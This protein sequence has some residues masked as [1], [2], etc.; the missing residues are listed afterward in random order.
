M[1][2]TLH[3]HKHIEE[4]GKPIIPNLVFKETVEKMKAGDKEVYEE[5]T[6]QYSLTPFQKEF[7]ERWK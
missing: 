2:V 4:D 7:I 6:K 5:I 3:N 1:K